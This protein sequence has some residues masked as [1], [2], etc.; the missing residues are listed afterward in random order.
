MLDIIDR[1]RRNRK[2][3]V[4]RAFQRETHLSADRFIYPVFIHA[5]AGRQPIA[6]MPGCSRLSL[7]ELR[8][9]ALGAW[10]D[11]VRS[12]VLFPAIDERLKSQKG[13]ESFNPEGLVPEAIRLLK[14]ELPDLAVVTDVALDPYSS[15]GHDG[16]VIDG[17]IVNDETVEVLCKQ[18][19]CQAAAG[20][21]IVAPSDM[22]DGRVGA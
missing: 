21:D 20:A 10:D 14:R 18:A 2:N 5:G 1:P 9:E 12:I 19:V 6:S 22:M 8:K 17:R 4:V 7:D 16:I 15:D 13:D 11:G 3:A